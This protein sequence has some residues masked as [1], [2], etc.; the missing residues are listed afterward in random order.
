MGYRYP[1]IF[2]HPKR[3]SITP[4]YHVQPF[5]VL[6]RL[7]MMAHSPARFAMWRPA[8]FLVSSVSSKPLRAPAAFN[9]LAIQYS[10]RV[11]S[12]LFSRFPFR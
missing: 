7:N 8:T 11:G 9:D 6:L 10:V 5:Q 2:T 1:G 12:N 4:S 3:C